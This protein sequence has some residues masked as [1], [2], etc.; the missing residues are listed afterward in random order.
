[1]FPISWGGE[2][3]AQAQLTSSN[4]A[5]RRCNSKGRIQQSIVSARCLLI[6][7]ARRPKGHLPCVMARLQSFR[8]ASGLLGCRAGS[9]RRQSGHWCRGP[10]PGQ[11]W[12]PGSAVLR[13]WHPSPPEGG[14]VESAAL[15]D[16][17]APT[18]PLPSTPTCVPGESAG[19]LT[20]PCFYVGASIFRMKSEH[21]RSTQRSSGDTGR[22][23]AAP[24]S[25]PHHHAGPRDPLP[26]FSH[27]QGLESTVI[28]SGEST[29]PA[30]THPTPVCVAG[31][32][33]PS[34]LSGDGLGSGKLPTTNPFKWANE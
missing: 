24:P 17:C 32:W 23:L 8:R 26:G 33:K 3:D 5:T 25:S 27:L 31:G 9:A 6:P 11:R 12:T 1:M 14:G 29:N 13:Q 30:H 21:S 34:L 15:R 28:S 20:A 4:D 19:W 7:F 22:A 18:H 16:H 2:S 10:R